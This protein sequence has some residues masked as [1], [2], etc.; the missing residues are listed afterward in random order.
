MRFL[1]YHLLTYT[2][3][4]QQTAETIIVARFRKVFPPSNSM[5]LY[6]D[7]GLAQEKAV[8]QSKCSEKRYNALKDAKA[9][10]G[11][12]RK[13]DVRWPS[14]PQATPTRYQE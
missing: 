9:S 13:K 6:V 10:G 8:I 4:A 2:K 7:G 14:S 11:R 1:L 12:F 3:H 5:Q